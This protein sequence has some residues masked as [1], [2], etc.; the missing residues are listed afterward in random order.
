MR[1]K[2]YDGGV[3]WRLCCGGLLG[4]QKTINQVDMMFIF[5]AFHG[6]N[7]MYVMREPWTMLNVAAE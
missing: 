4:R 3:F 5:A 7:V 2:H 1:R 6:S